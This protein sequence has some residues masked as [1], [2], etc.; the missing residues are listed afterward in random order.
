[1]DFSAEMVELAASLHAAVEFR[2]ADAGSLPFDDGAFDAVVSNFLVPHVADLPAVVA[3]LAR[4]VRPGGRVALT[5]WD[6]EPDTYPRCVFKAISESGAIPPPDLPPGPPFFQYVAEDEFAALLHDA[7]LED[8]SVQPLRFTHRVDDLDAFWQDLL[9]GTV[10]AR[11][12]PRAAARAPGQ[13]PAC[14]RG[15][16]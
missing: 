1:V 5:T 9:G 8:V 4:V 12:H 7:G 11:P 6:P 2:Q 14:V 10:R 3:E 16:P 15:E 13:D